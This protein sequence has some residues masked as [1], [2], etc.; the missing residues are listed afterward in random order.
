[1]IRQRARLP[2]ALA[3]PD[4][5]RESI[6]DGKAAVVRARDQ[7]AA[8]IGAEID[9]A[10]SATVMLPPGRRFRLRWPALLAVAV[11]QSRR[12]GDALRHRTRPFLSCTA[13]NG[14]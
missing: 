3:E 6:D 12:T 11:Q 9:R 14:G 7:Q 1:H 4:N 2:E 10:I 5:A 8:V 13:G